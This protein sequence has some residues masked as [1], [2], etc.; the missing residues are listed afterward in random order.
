MK[1]KRIGRWVIVLFL[2]AALPVMTAVMA[3]EEPAALDAA[4]LTIVSLSSAGAQANLGSFHPSLSDD[5]RFVAFVTDATNLVPGDTNG[6]S[7][8]FVRDRQTGQ[9]TRVS[10][11]SAGAQANNHT[12]IGK[13]S[14]DGRYVTFHS[15]ASNLV[16]GD[17]NNVADVFV[18]DRQTG[19]TSR[20]SVSSAG[21]Q[22]N[23]ESR[24]PDISADGRFVTFLSGASN[25]V[26]GDTNG[27]FDVFIRDRQAATTRRVSLSSSGA[28]GN[29][30]SN[31]PV[32]AVSADGRYVAFHSYATN[33]VPGDT[34]GAGDIFVRDRV[35]NQTT[36]VSIN[37]TG[38]QGDGWSGYPA[39][40]AD[41]RYVSFSSEATNL[42]PGDTNNLIDIFVHD[43][44]TGQTSRVSV[45]SA[46][47]Q[48]D[49]DT[50]PWEAWSALSG[51][52]RYVTFWSYATNLV[53]GDT[54]NW[55][56]VFIHD[57]Q[58]G[59]TSR[60]SVSI[61]G[62]QGNQDSGVFGLDLSADGRYLAFN[63]YATNLVPGDATGAADIFLW[64]R[65]P[66]GPRI[67]TIGDSITFGQQQLASRY[68]LG[69][70]TVDGLVNQADLDKY[71][72]W[73]NGSEQIPPSTSEAFKR[74]NADGNLVINAN[75]KAIANDMVLGRYPRA[76]FGAKAINKT[77]ASYRLPLYQLFSRQTAYP[78]TF[79]GT[80]DTEKTYNFA[81]YP[82]G[83]G[84]PQPTAA[85]IAFLGQ[86]GKTTAAVNTGTSALF[87]IT[88][89]LRELKNRNQPPDV[90]LIHLGTVDIN[91]GVL[92][93]ATQKNLNGILAKLRD[94]AGGG[95]A[96][97]KVYVAQ[98]IPVGYPGGACKANVTFSGVCARFA[99]AYGA[100]TP[101][102]RF[103]ASLAT[104][105][106]PVGTGNVRRC[107]NVST[108][109]S[110]VYLV[111]QHA[112]F[113][114]ENWLIASDEVYPNRQGECRIALRWYEALRATEFPSLPAAATGFCDPYPLTP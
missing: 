62:A 56:D 21:A 87:G 112:G 13:I 53:S 4:T 114:A 91:K 80:V 50:D 111:D 3:Q 35:N 64:D 61:A 104:W 83:A 103:N 58:T 107:A 9:T 94:P 12:G 47:G 71:T 57:R 45:S 73:L 67:L 86:S 23:G 6:I 75:D 22:G 82:G 34:N 10:V 17:T 85:Q 51:D 66:A 79:V 40:S 38:G 108:A 54:G 37:S 110:P 84:Y 43:R 100:T 89:A 42:V 97:V 18:H 30:S 46:G 95:N 14:A 19:T 33:L 96:A 41:G 88:P 90:A 20:V 60:I 101:V 109:S 93:T 24:S 27:Y 113:D 74:A 44:Q 99:Y 49:Q 25:L 8:V 102:Q 39:I 59:Q 2:L 28:Q 36:R 26:S 1:T 52:G 65:G 11:S 105:C 72:R 29:D 70:A 92:W 106:G 78:F 63:S 77:L 69:D 68:P 15:L 7:D 98:V 76:W 31:L 5:G 16:A 32:A 55:A 81:G 48:Q